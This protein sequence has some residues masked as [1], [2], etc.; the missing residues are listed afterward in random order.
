MFFQN[1]VVERIGSLKLLP[2]LFYGSFICRRNLFSP[3][4]GVRR[5]YLK[6]HLCSFRASYPV[7][8]SLLK[9]LS[10]VHGVQSVEQTLCIGADAQAPLHHLLLNNGVAAAH[11]HA[12]HHLVIGK[13]GA[14]SGAPVHHRLAQIGYAVVHQHLLL[15]LFAHGAPLVG[16]EAQLLALCHVESLGALLVEVLN[17]LL[18]RLRLVAGVAVERVEHLLERP[19]RPLVIFRVARAHLPVPVER[20]SYLV[21]LLAVVADV[22]LGGHRRVLS[23]LYG[24]L[25]RRQSVGVVAHRVEHVVAAHALVACVYV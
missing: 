9:R 14:Q 25:L 12:V 4:G 23:R 6:F 13:H 11:A 3:T 2:F 18:Y 16:R 20:E 22:L 5:G 15:F 19:L 8:L 24:V 17:E 10:P 7:A 21:Q 1:I